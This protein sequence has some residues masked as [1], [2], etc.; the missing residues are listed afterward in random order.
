MKALDSLLFTENASCA[1]RRCGYEL[2]TEEAKVEPVISA[3]EKTVTEKKLE[4]CHMDKG[5]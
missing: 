2:Q 1:L 3:F 4:E 5:V